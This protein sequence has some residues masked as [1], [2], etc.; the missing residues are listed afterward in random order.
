MTTK[1]REVQNS[2]TSVKARRLLKASDGGKAALA[3]A[4]N[5]G[6]TRLGSRKVATTRVD[7]RLTAKRDAFV[8][9]M[10]DIRAIVS[11]FWYVANAPTQ[12]AQNESPAAVSATIKV[13]GIADAFTF[14]Y[15]AKHNPAF[16]PEKAGDRGKH[17]IRDYLNYMAARAFPQDAGR[18]FEVFADNLAWSARKVVKARTDSKEG[19]LMAMTLNRLESDTGATIE[20]LR[21]GDEV[22]TR[23]AIKARGANLIRSLEVRREAGVLEV[24]RNPK[25]GAIREGVTL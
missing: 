14:A 22:Y 6:T 2:L 21:V 3:R 16:N 15:P 17:A 8:A 18:V 23:D 24:K 11:A 20:S 13:E 25:R 19:A 5:N 1:N 9:A 12:W 4:T 10:A 7:P